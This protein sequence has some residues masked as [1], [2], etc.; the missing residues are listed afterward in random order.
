MTYG[1]TLIGANVDG[2]VVASSAVVRRSHA[3]GGVFGLFVLEIKH[4]IQNT[5][6]KLTCR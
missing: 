2:V 4:K 1:L 5:K 6:H 3:K